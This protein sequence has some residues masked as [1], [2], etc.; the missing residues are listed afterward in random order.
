MSDTG[1]T[2]L[3]ANRMITCPGIG[4]V[5]SFFGSPALWQMQKEKPPRLKHVEKHV[6]KMATALI[7]GRV[8]DD[9]TQCQ[10]DEGS[11]QNCS[12]L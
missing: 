6:E 4:P 7:R 5:E 9:I 11:V 10:D 2:C 3:S 12:N 1:P 8:G